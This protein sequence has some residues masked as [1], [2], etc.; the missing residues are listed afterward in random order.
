M[1]VACWSAIRADA[2][3]YTRTPLERTHT[4]GAL[5][6]YYGVR[7]TAIYRFGK[8]LQ[9][10]SKSPAV[11]VA[12]PLWPLYWLAAAIMRR[13]YGIHLALSAHI[14]P[15]LYIGHLGG[16]CLAHCE[17]GAQCSIGQQTK[18]GSLDGGPGP[19]IGSRV[20]IGAHSKIQGALVIE[21]GATIGAGARVVADVPAKTLVMGDPARPISRNYD[22][23]SL[24][25]L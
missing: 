11:V 9:R 3:R 20:W 24:L 1:S 5:F 16:I 23:T 17:L 6:R 15:G 19:R 18:I 21:D 10:W 14:G 13:G 2:A 25:V 7:A 22:N 8:K 12:L 4:A